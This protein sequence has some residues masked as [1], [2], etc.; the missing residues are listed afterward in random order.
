MASENNN[1]VSLLRLSI[2]K[3]QGHSNYMGWRRDIRTVLSNQKLWTHI[4]DNPPP[5][6]LFSYREPDLTDI[7]TT[8]LGLTR[9]QQTE[10]LRDAIHDYKRWRAWE[11]AE[12]NAGQ[13][14]ISAITPIVLSRIAGH[15]G[16]IKQM[17]EAL[18]REYMGVN[19]IL[20]DTELERLHNSKYDDF[21]SATAYVQFVKTLVDLLKDMGIIIPAFEHSHILLKGL[22]D[23]FRD[24]I[25]S[26]RGDTRAGE[27]EILG[28]RIISAEN[29][30]QKEQRAALPSANAVRESIRTKRCSHCNR[31]NHNDSKC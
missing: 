17:W 19:F 26:L 8:L 3:L 16:S 24:V 2:P 7:Q 31:I 1:T 5:E 9:A 4:T 21:G 10:R 25:I 23:S 27:P 29:N 6:P 22:G 28:D 20:A 13:I 14:M 12:V 30:I 11:A 15:S 18:Q